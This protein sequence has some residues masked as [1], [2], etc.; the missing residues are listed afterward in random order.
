M[1][2]Y[3]IMRNKVI[4]LTLNLTITLRL[5]IFVTIIATIIIQT[6]FSSDDHGDGLFFYQLELYV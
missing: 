5:V 6:L 2:L 4:S 3:K 1:I